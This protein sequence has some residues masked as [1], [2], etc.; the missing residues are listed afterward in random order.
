VEVISSATISTS[1]AATGPVLH[2][3]GYIQVL[4]IIVTSV[5]GRRIARVTDRYECRNHRMGFCSRDLRQGLITKQSVVRSAVESIA[6]SWL[7]SLAG[8]LSLIAK[9]VPFY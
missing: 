1:Q 9:P 6:A 5:R 8:G 7:R 4:G 2:S 3:R